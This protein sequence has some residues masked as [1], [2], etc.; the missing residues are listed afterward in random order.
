MIATVANNCLGVSQTAHSNS[1][2]SRETTKKAFL[3]QG[4]FTTDSNPN[5]T[6]SCLEKK[7][8]GQPS[9]QILLDHG[10]IRIVPL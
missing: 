4:G 6:E 2:A 5:A 7:F 1:H 9:L 10:T 3:V 8:T